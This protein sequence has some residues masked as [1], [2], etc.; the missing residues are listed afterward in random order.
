MVNAVEDE[1][2]ESNM[3]Q[4]I[5]KKPKDQEALQ[6]EEMSIVKTEEHGSRRK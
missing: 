3:K 6:G 1:G 4:T 5:I 2:S